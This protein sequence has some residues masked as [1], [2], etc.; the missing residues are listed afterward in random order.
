VLH[1]L[2]LSLATFLGLSALACATAP[3]GPPVPA[4]SA[5]QLHALRAHASPITGSPDDYNELLE[6][7]GDHQFVLL[8]ESTHGTREFYRERARL[9]R[10]LIEEK[11]FTVLVLEADWPDAYDLNAFVH[12]RGAATATDALRTFTRF[13]QWMWNNEEVRDL[14]DWL[15]EHNRRTSTTDPVGV[16]GMDL[17]SVVESMEGVVRFLR[18]VDAAA[19]ER[20]QDRYRCLK[21][22]RA[23]TIEEY[24]VDVARGGPSCKAGV[25]AQLQEL[26]ERVSRAAGGHRPGDDALISAWQ[27]SR[28]VANGEAYYRTSYSG[29]VPSWNLR[30]QHMADTIDAV[31]QHL[32][33][34]ATG[35]AKVVVWAHNSHIGDARATERARVG[36]L[37]VGQVMRQ[38]HGGRAI[39]IGFTTYAGTVRAAAAWGSGGNVRQL[40]PAIA[41]SFASVFHAVGLPAFSLVLRDREVAVQT[42]SGARPERFVGVVYSPATERASHYFST[43]LARQY[44]AVVHVDETS[45]IGLNR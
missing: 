33:G 7:V 28:V 9:T 35:P 34:R 18:T 32:N 5:G 4:A 12:G 11:G 19:A 38:R 17:Y 15:R 13:P 45:A 30:D 26:T 10:R 36:E 23:D 27:N 14:I 20:A 31:A 42:L 22:Y 2:R 29:A 16:Y 3:P 40:K 37:N 24:A 6:M 39:L 8:G 1:T 21:R 44:D 25:S 41:E 43:D